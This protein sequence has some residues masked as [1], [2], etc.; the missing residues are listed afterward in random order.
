MLH[1]LSKN[2]L[3]LALAAVLL[4]F[5]YPPRGGGLFKAI[6]RRDGGAV[7]FLLKR[8]AEIHAV[9]A[10][11]VG[12]FAPLQWAVHHLLYAVAGGTHENIKPANEADRKKSLDIIAVLLAKGADANTLDRHGDTPLHHA[13]RF[14][15]LPLTKLLLTHNAFI[16]IRNSAG[17]TVLH[18]I[19]RDA[20]GY[21]KRVELTELLLSE[22]ANPS[23]RSKTNQTALDIV[24]I[25]N[26]SELHHV[27]SS[28]QQLPEIGDGF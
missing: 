27:L 15:H 4:A 22:G 18:V 10:T 17:E 11:D 26:D 23:T 6:Q 9:Y 7:E 12:D 16:N 5:S 3:L 14:L 28:F 13:A 8:G 1:I 19:A 25:N 2:L 24:F 20:Q 21:R